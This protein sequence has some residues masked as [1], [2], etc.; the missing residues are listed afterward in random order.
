MMKELATQE[1]PIK[2][3]LGAKK[4]KSVYAK[5][6][7]TFAHYRDASP[8]LARAEND[9][10]DAATETGSID[11][12]PVE[13]IIDILSKRIND[14]RLVNRM[15][16]NLL[17]DVGVLGRGSFSSSREPLYLNDQYAYSSVCR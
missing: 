14:C 12:L 1:T 6:A 13:N 11:E 15:Y 8:H 2:L 4:L 17:R 10:H 5:I 16:E 9:L 7:A 3:T